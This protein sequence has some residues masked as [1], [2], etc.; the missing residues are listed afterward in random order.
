MRQHYP[1][2]VGRVVTK[3]IEAPSFCA[4]SLDIISSL[5]P[6]GVDLNVGKEATFGEQV[7]VGALPILGTVSPDYV[8]ALSKVINDLNTTYADFLLSEEGQGFNGQ[9]CVIGMLII[10]CTC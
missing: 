9:I 8:E 7:P 10:V 3:L 5:A 4:S 1:H 6:Y 2:L